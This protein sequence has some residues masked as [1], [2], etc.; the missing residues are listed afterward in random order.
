MTLLPCLPPAPGDNQL[1]ATSSA[2]PHPTGPDGC[3][4]CHTPDA[5]PHQPL[6]LPHPE[7]VQTSMRATGFAFQPHPLAGVKQKQVFFTPQIR[8]SMPFFN[9]CLFLHCFNKSTFFFWAVRAQKGKWKVPLQCCSTHPCF[10]SSW[11]RHEFLCTT[12][13]RNYFNFSSDPG[14]FLIT[15][16]TNCLD[17]RGKG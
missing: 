10:Y 5:C 1:R 12:M 4:V 3:R 7:Q 11:A 16:L 9:H 15:R 2:T 13:K 14:F 17:W 6:Y 8:Y